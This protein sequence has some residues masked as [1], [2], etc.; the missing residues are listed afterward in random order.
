MGVMG[1]TRVK[2][3]YQRLLVV[4]AAI[5]VVLNACLLTACGATAAGKD[6]SPSGDLFPSSNNSSNFQSLSTVNYENINGKTV[7]VDL[8]KREQNEALNNPNVGQGLLIYQ[9]IK[10]KEK[11]PDEDVA[12]TC[13]SFHYSVVLSVC[14]DPKSKYFG[15]MRSLYDQD[16]DDDGFYRLSYLLVWAAKLGINVITIGQIDASPVWQNDTMRDDYHFDEYFESHLNDDSFIA[17]KKVGDFLKFRKANWTSYGDKSASDMMHVK[18]CTVTHYLD[19]N[20]VEHEAGVWLG[21][22]NID[23]IDSDG[24]N[25]NNGVQT[26]VIITGHEA[27]RRVVYN[28]TAIMSDYCG[29]EEIA[30]FRNKINKMNT[31]QID[32]IMAGREDEIPSDEQIVY[33]GSATDNVFEMY[34]TPIGGNAGTW[35][36]NYNPYSKY[37]GKL[38]PSVAGGNSITFAWNNAKYLTNF[39]FS[40][41]LTDSLVYAFTNNAH[42]TNKLYL[43]LPGL[44]AGK[45]DGLIEGQN[46]GKKAVNDHVTDYYHNKDFQLSYVEN[47]LRYYVTV[48]N[49]LNFHQGAAS[50]Q[51]N[52]FLVIKETRYTGNDTYVDFGKGLTSGVITE[53]DRIAKI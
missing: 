39:E 13:T 46:I 3:I 24:S 5:L 30:L 22:I 19:F 6:L 28:Y 9:C 20:G 34:F 8:F 18:S 2:S 10:Y 17:G 42:L 49:S 50:Y 25:G 37:I 41:T 4:F 27:I 31:N 32:L 47:G 45:F 53:N 16:Y 38:N 52:T 21:S 43:H 14:V 26:G 44:D 36:P 35:E 51:T 11:H 1:N 7:T 12:I 48:F 33:L 15:Y 23:G 40:K 29:Q